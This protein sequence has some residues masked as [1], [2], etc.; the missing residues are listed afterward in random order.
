MKRRLAIIGVILLV[1]GVFFAVFWH[2]A[3]TDL[4]TYWFRGHH[5]PKE[6]PTEEPTL[7]KAVWLL[8]YNPFP[9][10]PM[11]AFTSDLRMGIYRQL[12][13]SISFALLGVC[14]IAFHN[15]SWKHLPRT[16]AVIKWLSGVSSSLLLG[17]IVGSVVAWP[18]STPKWDR[19][20]DI[21]PN[22]LAYSANYGDVNPSIVPPYTKGGVVLTNSYPHEFWLEMDKQGRLTMH[23]APFARRALYNFLKHQREKKPSEDIHFILWVDYRCRM[24]H[25]VTLVDLIN[26][27]SPASIR[28]VVNHEVEARHHEL[29]AMDTF[30][31]QEED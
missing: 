24:E 14:C 5:G 15:G 31:I 30:P 10:E 21:D 7:Y 1:V 6:F 12:L 22:I 25:R 17:L 8:R 19:Q 11:P 4:S 3:A 28:Y 20:L 27:V 2:S 9:C 23:N 16:G 18:R 29:R 13:L 26:T